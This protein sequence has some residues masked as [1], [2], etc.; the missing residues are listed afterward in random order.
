MRDG[1]FSDGVGPGSIVA[2]AHGDLGL[3]IDKEGFFA[4]LCSLLLGQV[5]FTV[6][7]LFVDGVSFPELRLTADLLHFSFGAW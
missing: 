3:S 5:S 7:S 2:S 6:V 4:K 1:G